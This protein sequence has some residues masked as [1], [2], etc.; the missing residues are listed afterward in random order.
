MTSYRREQLK[1]RLKASGAYCKLNPLFI[2]IAVSCR[3]SIDTWISILNGNQLRGSELMFLDRNELLF[4][5]PN[6]NAEWI[7]LI[8]LHKSWLERLHAAIQH[9]NKVLV[10][11]NLKKFNNSYLADDAE[12]YLTFQ[13][14]IRWNLPSNESIRHQFISD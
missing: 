1:F 8:A 4:L 5:N 6:L 11:L 13:F 12:F 14:F 2:Y 3:N 7:K 9:L 10:E